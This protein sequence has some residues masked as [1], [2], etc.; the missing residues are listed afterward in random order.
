MIRILV[1]GGVFGPEGGVVSPA[2]YSL[3]GP[4]A[5]SARNL[6]R[7]RPSLVWKRLHGFALVI[8]ARHDCLYPVS[9][10]LMCNV[11]VGFVTLAG[12]VAVKPW[13]LRVTVT[14]ETL[15]PIL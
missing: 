3:G 5:L 1:P 10:G 2:A 9:S 6:W 15:G 13:L 14:V 12:R 8:C 4:A 11:G 7:C